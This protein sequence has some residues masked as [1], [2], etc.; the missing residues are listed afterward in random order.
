MGIGGGSIVTVRDN[1][2]SL[3]LIFLS[4]PPT[5]NTDLLPGHVRV[6][7]FRETV[8]R[9]FKVDLL[10]DCPS[11]FTLSTGDVLLTLQRALA[12]LIK[13]DCWK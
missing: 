4:P 6:Y 8:P 2:G 5:C 1:T 12:D 3:R 13:C 7:N 10:S 9:R 11:T